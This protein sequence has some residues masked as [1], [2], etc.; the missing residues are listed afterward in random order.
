MKEQNEDMKLS[1]ADARVEQDIANVLEGIRADISAF[2]ELASKIGRAADTRIACKRT[3]WTP[4]QMY[5]L[6]RLAN[7][8]AALM[9][10]RLLK[11]DI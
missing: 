11:R 1:A 2:G 4:E 7:V 6:V 8:G 9:T 10:A 3:G 5:Q